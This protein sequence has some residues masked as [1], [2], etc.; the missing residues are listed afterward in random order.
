MSDDDVR[1]SQRAKWAALSADW[2][3]WNAVITAQLAPVGA[4]MIASLGLVDGERH[5]DIAAGTGEPG[6][7]IARTIPAGHVVLTDLA[8]EM[9]AVAERRAAEQGISNVEVQVCSADDLPFADASFDSVS[10]RFGYMF[11]PDL[12][13]AT[14]EL[15][16]VLRP[17]GRLSAAVW[18]REEDNP[19][20]SIPLAAIRTEVDLP[21]SPPDSPHMYR[22]AAPGYV[23]ALFSAAGLQGIEES[24]VGVV[25]ERA[26]PSECWEVLS[27]HLSAV[28][29]VLQGVD[30]DAQQRVGQLVVAE[31]ER[32][33]DGG[34][35]RVPGLARVTVGTRG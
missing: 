28:A 16:R 19:W 4:A 12:A 7:S 30:A 35:T 27:E 22:C 31:L 24:D 18:A 3:K 23:G 9:L 33:A 26:T 11:F 32:F 8:A 29:G 10:V 6:L 1:E 14:A 17:G 21:P 20:V 13:A 25:L 15:V 5:L 34:A 2:D